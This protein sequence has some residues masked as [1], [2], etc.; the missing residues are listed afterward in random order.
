VRAGGEAKVDLFAEGPTPNWALPLPDAVAG[1]PA[2]VKRFSFALDGLPSGAAADG[3]VLT[4]TAVA[5]DAAIEVTY[6]L[7]EVSNQ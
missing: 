4:L 6:R 2:G 3:A 1:A 7:P 5:G